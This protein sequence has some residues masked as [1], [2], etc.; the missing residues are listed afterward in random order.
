MGVNLQLQG[1]A[2]Y[3]EEYATDGS[4]GDKFYPGTTDIVS[5]NTELE[6]IDHNDTEDE[7]QVL[8]GE[9]VVKRNMTIAFTTAD[10]NNTFNKMA[11]LASEAALTQTAVTDEAVV[12]ASALADK[13]EDLG[14][15]DIT[16][17]VVK[18]ATDTTTYVMGTDYTYDR[19]WGT[20]IILSTGSISDADEIHVTLTA[21]AI[22]DGV[23]LTSFA[24]DKVEYRLTYQGRSSKGRNEKHVFEK[25][26][27]AME[28][29][30]SLKSGEKAYTLINFTGAV[31]KEN[32]KTHSMQTY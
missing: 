29:D 22:T 4:L 13:V 11:Y 32:G 24:T 18:D 8:D 19:K 23:S 31:L 15:M 14:F 2:I 26:S 6:K 25:V 16:A 7:E 5:F 27:I 20:L 12:I 17:L 10:I 21:N 28:G 30:R 9:D 3:L 1:G